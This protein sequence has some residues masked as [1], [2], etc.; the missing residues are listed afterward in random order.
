MKIK[1]NPN[2]RQADILAYLNQHTEVT[3][4]AIL[5]YF[6]DI[7][8][9]KI[10]KSTLS[11]DIKFLKSKGYPIVTRY[12]YISLEK[13]ET[14]DVIPY[15]E[16]L[17]PAIIRKWIILYNLIRDYAP[18]VGTPYGLPL[19]DLYTACRDM[20][21]RLTPAANA[22]SS[23]V[24]FKDVRE[25]IKN[26]DIKYSEHTP[27][28]CVKNADKQLVPSEGLLYFAD[29]DK[30]TAFLLYDCL[31]KEVS[32]ALF[33]DLKDLLKKHWPE[34]KDSY[35]D[36]RE[37]YIYIERIPPTERNM[38]E[39][40]RQL[41]YQTN[42][43]NITCCSEDNINRPILYK[44]FETVAIIY[45]KDVNHLFLL[46]RSIADTTDTKKEYLLP[47]S[48]II[49]VQESDVKNTIHANADILEPYKTRVHNTSPHLDRWK[50]RYKEVFR[51]EYKENIDDCL[52]TIK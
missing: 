5:N 8:K 13:Q 1:N 35:V 47:F 2:K 46:G 11:E 4:K 44:D 16:K 25:L 26:G 45:S 6:K 23:Q 43:L 7:K 30:N 41:S 10:A 48:Q 29:I 50:K 36:A 37:K 39:H 15:Y 31:E 40:I 9:N 22:M 34:I 38:F 42:C 52:S 12:G 33:A 27:N 20:Y 18:C 49:K 17:C 3:R 19:T 24:F 51:S 32:T 28:A 21:A 14:G